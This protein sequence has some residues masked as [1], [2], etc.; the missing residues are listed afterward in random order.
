MLMLHCLNV[1]GKEG[2]GETSREAI[3]EGEREKVPNTRKFFNLENQITGLRQVKVLYSL[4]KALLNSASILAPHG[5][6]KVLFFLAC[7]GDLGFSLQRGTD[8]VA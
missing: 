1:G 4:G 6:K 8:A 7:K 2:G 5:L 3:R